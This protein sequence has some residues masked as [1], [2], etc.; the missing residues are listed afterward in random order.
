MLPKARRCLEDIA[1]AAGF[2]RS[3]LEG[4][5]LA[6]YRSDRMLRQAIERKSI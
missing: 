5:T 6:D 3:A 4:R 2:I 1:D